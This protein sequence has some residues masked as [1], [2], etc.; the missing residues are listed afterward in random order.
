[1]KNL[2]KFVAI[3]RGSA[4]AQAANIARPELVAREHFDLF[5]GVGRGELLPYGSYYLTRFLNERPLARLRDDLRVLG[6][7]RAAISGLAMCLEIVALNAN[8]IA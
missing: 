1:M 5:V 4:L 3:L 7:A 6:I 2:P 8:S